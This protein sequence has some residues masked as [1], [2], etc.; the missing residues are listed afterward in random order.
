MFLFFCRG[1][2]VRQTSWSP[3]QAQLVF[4]GPTVTAG[5]GRRMFSG[6]N[7][8]RGPV[9][10]AEHMGH[11]DRMERSLLDKC[12]QLIYCHMCHHDRCEIAR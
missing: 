4:P 9:K 7:G 10:S 12:T 1:V 5:G 8:R 11:W 2:W 6:D 3:W